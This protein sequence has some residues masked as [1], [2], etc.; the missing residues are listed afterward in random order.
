MS[1]NHSVLGEG[2]SSEGFKRNNAIRAFSLE[3]DLAVPSVLSK[4][5]ANLS[6]LSAPRNAAWW[7][8]QRGTW[9]LSSR[10]V[11][12]SEFR[13]V[14]WI[15]HHAGDR[16]LWRQNCVWHPVLTIPGLTARM[17]VQLASVPCPMHI[18]QGIQW[19]ALLT[20]SVELSLTT[21]DWCSVLF[22]LHEWVF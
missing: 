19:P 7:W 5:L 17:F 4:C 21:K 13:A 2:C 14:V 1:V 16:P 9:L 11:H 20:G 15:C 6:L 18:A 12:S 22:S 8:W 3:L 10:A